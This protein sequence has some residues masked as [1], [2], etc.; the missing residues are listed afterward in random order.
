MRVPA[1]A[2]PAETG[3]EQRGILE[4]QIEIR[5]TAAAISMP[6]EK[7]ASHLP[8]AWQQRPTS[9]LRSSGGG[10]APIVGSPASG[11]PSGIP[12]DRTWLHLL[13]GCKTLTPKRGEACGFLWCT[14]LEEVAEAVTMRRIKPVSVCQSRN[15]AFL[16]FA[17]LDRMLTR[18]THRRQHRPLRRAHHAAFP[19]AI[20]PNGTKLSQSGAGVPPAF[21]RQKGSRDGHPTSKT[22]LILAPFRHR[23]RAECR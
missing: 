16:L 5:R 13:C 18:T 15:L 14:D 7:P 3:E 17:H 4:F 23:A 22:G 19:G 10:K 12:Q 11:I 2:K 1:P 20:G 8:C 9:D 21:F 6:D